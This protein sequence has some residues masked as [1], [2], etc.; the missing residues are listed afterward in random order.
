[1]GRAEDL[2]QRMNAGGETA[3]DQLIVDRE[4]EQL[5]LDFKRSADGGAGTT[6]HP[7]DRA[8]FAEAVSGFANSEGGVII[9]G[10]EC[11]PR[12]DA[13]DV[14]SAKVPIHNARRFL[15]LL[16]GAVSGCTLPPH[17]G[18]QHRAIDNMPGGPGYVVSYIPQSHL[19]PHQA[20]HA[21][22][23]YFIRAGSSFSPAPH[24]VIAGLFGRRPQPR[25]IHAW[26]RVNGQAGVGIRG[27]ARGITGRMYIVLSN[28]GPGIA[29]D[30]Y[31]VVRCASTRPG[32]RADVE[33]ANEEHWTMHGLRGGAM[34]VVAVDALKL[35]PGV[36]VSPA[37]IN[38]AFWPPF[39]QD[40][41]LQLAYG[42]TGS[43]T[44]TADLTIPVALIQAAYDRFQAAGA[45]Q[46]AAR[47]FVRDVLPDDESVTGVRL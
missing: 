7:K 31:L 27:T 6:L 43:P 29:R 30:I 5:F 40:F 28:Q 12:S 14:A 39:E 44:T 18:V 21:K 47:D 11:S 36:F 23:Y 37:Y 45:S 19:A 42:Q 2:F 3:I 38:M 33:V 1:M 13:G 22:P 24:G 4:A 26:M 20:Q 9:W 15:S 17:T 41:S 10:V 46:A 16:E 34:S 32:V 8:N 25:L 35:P